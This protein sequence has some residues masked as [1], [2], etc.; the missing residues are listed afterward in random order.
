[1]GQLYTLKKKKNTHW[2]VQAFTEWY[3]TWTASSPGIGHLAEV[4]PTKT[5]SVECG[6]YTKYD[7]LSVDEIF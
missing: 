5:S 7:M 4:I 1:L 6:S 2:I 3:R